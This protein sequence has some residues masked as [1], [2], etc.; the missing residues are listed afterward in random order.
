MIIRGCYSN[1][2]GGS[3]LER[4]VLGLGFGLGLGAP[5]P[6]YSSGKAA[7]VNG[8]QYG[9]ATEGVRL[10]NQD[11]NPNPYPTLNQATVIAS[12]RSRVRA[13]ASASARG[14]ARARLGVRLVVRLGL[15]IGLKLKVWSE[16][17]WGSGQGND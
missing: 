5:H 8:D 13:R 16:L 15:A 4:D 7:I 17:Y 2:R 1:I 9:I 12:C 14:K 3:G 6:I 11:Y 10:L